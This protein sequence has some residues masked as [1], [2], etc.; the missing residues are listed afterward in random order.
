MSRNK[1]NESAMMQRDGIWTIRS[2]DKPSRRSVPRGE[3]EEERDAAGPGRNVR[4]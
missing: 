3:G 4:L 1:K 2:R